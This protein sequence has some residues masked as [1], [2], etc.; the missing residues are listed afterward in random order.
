MRYNHFDMLPEN[1]FQPVGKRMTLEGG[2]SAPSGPT[3][4]T[5]TNTN[6]PDYAQPY[7]TN[8]L[9]AAQSQIYNP[10]G[11]GFN[12]YTPY[13]NNP[14]NYVAGFSP[15]QQQAQ[16]SAANLQVPGQY[17]LGSNLAAQAGYGSLG[18]ANQ[19]QGLMGQSLGYGNQGAMLGNM[20]ANMAGMG[21]GAGQNFA[22]QATNPYAVQAYMNPYLQSSLQPQLQEMQRQYGITGQQEQANA[23]QQGAFGGSREA[24]MAAE[25]E[26]NKNTAMNQAIGQGYNTAFN[27]AQAQQLAAAN[28]GL[29]GMQ[30]G[31]AAINTGIAGAQ[32]G[33]QGVGQGVNAGQYGLSGLAQ[34]GAQGTNL[35]NIG[36]QQLGAQ[37]GVIG[38]QAQQGATQQAQQ[39]NIINQA[40]QNYA[41]A[42]QYP[43]LQLGTL[44]SMLRGLPMQQATTSMY[45]AAPSAVQQ[46]AGLGTAGIGLSSLMNKSA[47][48]GL[49][50]D[51]VSRY[52]AGGAIPM[53]MMSNDQ[54]KQVQQSPA[55]SAIGKVVAQ[56]QLGLNQ[57]VA[58]N[59]Q[60]AQVLSQP[61]P[62]PQPGQGLPPQ[63]QVAQAPQNRAGLGAI[64]TPPDLT[65][66]R[67]ASGGILAFADGDVIQ[68]EKNKE[69]ADSLIGDSMRDQGAASNFMN[70]VPG[71]PM[72]AAPAAPQDGGGYTMTAAD[73][74]P[75][76]V[77]MPPDQ[78][79]A[80]LANI[81]VKKDG[82]IDEVAFLA[83][84]MGK[85]RATEAVAGHLADIKK[86]IEDRK[87]TMKD[88]ALMRFGLGLMSAPSRTGHGFADLL[89]NVGAS[90]TGAMN[91][92]GTQ[93]AQNVSD[94]NKVAD[95]EMNAAKADQ[96]RQLQLA[97]GIITAEQSRAAKEAALGQTKATQ[98]LQNQYR[99]D[100]LKERGGKDFMATV[101]AEEEN[102]RKQNQFA[103]LPSETIHAMAWNNVVGSLS[104]Y[105][106]GILGSPVPM[107]VP[108]PP[109]Q[110]AP[111]PGVL[112]NISNWWHNSG[113][114]PENTASAN[115]GA[116]SPQIDAYTAELARR[117]AAQNQS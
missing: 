46:L 3:N 54:L 4:T 98:D 44:N 40:I 62:L 28:L 65:T 30:A 9:N 51:K 97:Q 92:Y 106:S 41:T 14:A 61:L 47:G 117:K 77:A 34:A 89:T 67:A 35:A 13:S 19:A 48:G 36:T 2:G 96:A 27:N 25:N 83:Q 95:V 53:R 114:K 1:A 68:K 110:P 103:G 50:K 18:A 115:P 93:Q 58:N 101:R 111:P 59:P 37:Q 69:A 80:G 82:T 7:V 42:Q 60:A 10:S 31:N 56:G 49:Q 11:T 66:V 33:L 8:M 74:E 70:N 91:W 17:D 84:A 55:E 99:E 52:D 5:V 78:P 105:M 23:T 16:S 39:Q 113:T 107:R 71:L 85:D 22:N 112:E 109:A 87:A 20:A 104:P 45:Q 94:A 21:Y 86:E 64:A 108:K 79:A 15:L 6:I 81:P 100:A 12:A 26:R 90:G 43:Y 73:Q 32:T 63:Q 24:L 76:T 72:P 88:E 75:N 38:T 102:L 57:Y 29:Q 116:G